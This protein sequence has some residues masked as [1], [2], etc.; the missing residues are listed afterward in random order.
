M[1]NLAV[2]VGLTLFSASTTAAID[3]QVPHPFFFN[4]PRTVTGEFDGDRSET[5]V[6]IQAK[7]LVPVNNKMLVTIFGGPSFFSVEQDIVNDFEYSE[8]YPF[9]TATFTRAIAA[10]QSESAVGVNVG[11]DV[12][13]FFS[14]NVG[15]GGT[16]QYS[17]ATVEMTRA[18]GHGGRES[19]WSAGRRRTSAALLSR[20]PGP[21]SRDIIVGRETDDEVPAH[22]PIG[23]AVASAAV[24][25][26]HGYT[27]AEVENGAR[28]FQA[29]CATCHG[30]KGDAVRG[31]ALLSGQYKRATSD[32]QLVKII[33]EGIPGTSMPPN[34]YSA[35]EAGMIVA[36]L[37]GIAAGDNV[38]VTAGD[39]ARGKA[40]FEGKGKCATCHN[41]ESR[42]APSLADVGVLR[43]PLELE[44]SILDPSAELHPDYRYVRAVT[45]SGTVVT[46]RLLNQSTFSV[47]IL[48]SAQ[49]LRGF[50]RA[51][52]REFVINQTSEMPSYRG[53]LDSQEVADLV[54]YLTTLRGRR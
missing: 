16:V 13:Y 23:V 4:Q 5:A 3:A 24:S 49:N 35:L 41:P 27:R 17:G 48:D 28:L 38:T 19:R 25:A 11:G 29:S 7:W 45:K 9:D 52:L 31:V 14:P 47:Q 40:L 32:E 54:M 51:D 36:Y 20:V 33:I 6:H 42:T 34:N 43:R 12:A 2:G 1:E 22:R 21:G 26:Q 37:R 44:Q 8:S 18:F 10:S 46:G 50:N 53:T 39:L 30:P 15:V